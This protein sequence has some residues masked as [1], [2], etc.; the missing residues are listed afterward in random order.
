MK[1]TK[2]V[3]ITL[4]SLLVILLPIGILFSVVLSTPKTYSSTFVGGLNEKF[5]RLNSTDGEKIIIVGGS[6]VAFGID[7]RV[8]EEHLK[9]PVV[10]FGLYAA[11]GTKLMMDLSRSNIGEGDIVILSPELDPQTLSLY[12]SSEHTLEALDDDYS[13]ARYVRG[14]NKLSLLGGLWKHAGKKLELTCGEIPDPEGVYNSKS[15][16]EYGDVLPRMTDA[17]GNILWER[18]QNVMQLYYDPTTAIDLTPDIV[19]DDFLD[20]VNEYIRFCER[21]GAT[22]YFS[23]CPMNAAAI[24]DTSDPKVFSD[25]LEEKLDCEFISMIDSYIIDKAYFYDTN[26]HL[27]NSGVK[28]RT[29]TLIEDIML[30]EGSY[31][32]VDIEIP[33][34]PALPEADVKF[35][36]E[37]ENDVYFTYESL[38]NGALVITGLTELGKKQQTLTVPL[39]ADHTKITAI[40]KEAFSAGVCK[41]VIITEDTNVRNLLDGIFDNTTVE[42]LYIYYNFTDEAEKLVPP[43]NFGGITLHVKRGSQYLTHY[44]WQDTSGGYTTE[45][46]D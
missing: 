27:N 13:M 22:V 37:D 28:I 1:I 18:E 24:T 38:E 11:L 19:S 12:F 34:P 10:N 36:G 3:L 33:D 31:T 16:N 40:G 4:L 20:Y 26:F 39:G 7:S 42:D 41:T 44:D 46:F 25:Y 2:T 21:R 17:D 32:P 35:F 9:K 23:Y 43:G 15:L 45:V 14:D 5:E 29:K 6:S 30:A 8:M